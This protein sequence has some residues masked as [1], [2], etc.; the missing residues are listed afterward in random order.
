MDPEKK[1]KLLVLLEETQ[2]QFVQNFEVKKD[3]LYPALR[4]SRRQD[5]EFSAFLCSV[6]AY[7]RVQHIQNNTF[8]ILSPIGDQPVEWLLNAKEKNI[9]NLTKGWAH[10]WN[11]AEDM[12]A[13]LHCLQ[14]I[15]QEFESIE[16]FLNPQGTKDVFELIE[17]FHK[18]IKNFNSLN[19]KSKFWFF[20]PRPSLGS[21][22]KR[23]NLFLRWMVG[24]GEMDL[25]LWKS[26]PQSKL[27]IPLD[28][29]LLRQARSLKLTK[30]K[31]ANW[32]TATQITEELKSLDPQNPTRFDFALCHLGM[33]GHYGI[34]S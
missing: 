14:K 22:C 9:K 5:Q 24:S 12:E 25:N 33:Q 26:F 7:G 32:K 16:N 6:L 29:H 10:R 21:A 1:K 27:I 30:S 11:R 28:V 23:M 13:L 31:T 3:A 19:Q 34:N 20:F 2:R 4:Y 17:N 15:Y 8:A 18:K